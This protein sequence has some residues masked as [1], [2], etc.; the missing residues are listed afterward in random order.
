MYLTL[1]SDSLSAT[2]LWKDFL[3]FIDISGFMPRINNNVVPCGG[4][5]N[6]N[7]LLHERAMSGLQDSVTG[8]FPGA[9]NRK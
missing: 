5:L 3:Y 9:E 2:L 6:T 4:I 7:T 1:Q 8:T